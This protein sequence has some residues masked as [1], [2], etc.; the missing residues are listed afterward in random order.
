MPQ[1]NSQENEHSSQGHDKSILWSLPN[2]TDS[3]GRNI[4]IYKIS[5]YQQRFEYFIG[6]NSIH[7][8]KEKDNYQ[9]KYSI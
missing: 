5:I 4:Y 1:L 3:K 2:R 7:N 6:K 8:R 9:E